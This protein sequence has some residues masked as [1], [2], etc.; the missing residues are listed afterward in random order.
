M[1][2]HLS[3]EMLIDALDAAAEPL[4]HARECDGCGRRLDAL[5]EALGQ[6]T[7]AE[8]PEPSP[9][10]W[11]AFRAQVGRRIGAGSRASWRFAF[12][13]ALLAAASVLVATSGL[14]TGLRGPLSGPDV[15]VVPAS[16][17]SALPPESEDQSLPVLEGAFA[18]LG[19]DS[20]IADCRGLTHCLAALTDEE[21]QALAEAVRR[22]LAGRES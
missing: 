17:W 12:W 20:M 15:A 3:D 21:Q 22:E 13:P 1:R 18:S 7:E 9:L 2:G 4:S 5:R 16:L 11:Q 6:A 19:E 10:F 14:V 8:V